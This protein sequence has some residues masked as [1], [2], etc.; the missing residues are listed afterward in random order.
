[1]P[2]NAA[3]TDKARSADPGRPTVDKAGPSLPALI[4]NTT[5]GCATRKASTIESITARSSGALPTP[6][7]RLSTRGRLRRSA[8]RAAYSMARWMLPVI[9]IPPRAP[10]AIF[11]PSKW[12]PGATPSKPA[13]SKRPCPA[14]IPATC[15]P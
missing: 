9:V 3:P 11:K 2:G 8:K 4:V 13:T 6:K 7:L 15:V 12:A 5:V 14:A 1:M 10:F